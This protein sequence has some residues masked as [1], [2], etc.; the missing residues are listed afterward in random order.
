[1][2]SVVFEPLKLYCIII[3]FINCNNNDSNNNNGFNNTK[4]NDN[5]FTDI[6]FNTTFGKFENKTKKKYVVSAGKYTFLFV[7]PN[8]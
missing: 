8:L 3:I 6:N 1:M 5:N 2:V 4:S 7:I